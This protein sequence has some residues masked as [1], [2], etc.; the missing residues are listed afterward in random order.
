[1]KTSRLSSAWALASLLLLASLSGCYETRGQVQNRVDQA[2]LKAMNKLAQFYKMLYKQ[3]FVDEHLSQEVEVLINLSDTFYR[4]QPYENPSYEKAMLRMKTYRSA[5]TLVEMFSA[6]AN[7][8]KDSLMPDP[9]VKFALGA[10]DELAAMADYP[11]VQQELGDLRVELVKLSESRRT[12][13]PKLLGAMFLAAYRGLWKSEEHEVSV[14]LQDYFLNVERRINALP[15][16]IFDEAKLREMLQKPYGERPILA[17][18][19]KMRMIDQFNVDK[20]DALAWM[21]RLDAMLES[22]RALSLGYASEQ[23]NRVD[24]SELSVELLAETKEFKKMGLG[25][26]AQGAPTTENQD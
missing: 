4:Y 11:L 24:A 17:S 1:M 6:Y 3:T 16:S 12:E 5:R 14:Y 25:K 10:Y 19:Y 18:L 21:E 20:K 7:D 15:D 22:T 2:E 9:D 23:M 13:N 26:A 8:G